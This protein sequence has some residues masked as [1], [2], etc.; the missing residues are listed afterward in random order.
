MVVPCGA[1]SE[2]RCGWGSRSGAAV[3]KNSVNEDDPGDIAW[4]STPGMA[5]AP[6]NRSML[7]ALPSVSAAADCVSVGLLLT[8]LPIRAHAVTPTVRCGATLLAAL[9][10]ERPDE[11]LGVGFEHVVDLIEQRVNVLG[12]LFLPLGDVGL[13]L[14]LDLVDLV[15]L[16]LRPGLAAFVSGHVDSSLGPKFTLARQDDGGVATFG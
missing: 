13:A 7:T 3:L 12:E 10:H 8:T 11:V 4:R 6:L 16:A 15:G 14:D 9:L 1:R 2:T 5:S